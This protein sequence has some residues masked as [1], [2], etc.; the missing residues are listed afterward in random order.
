VLGISK[1]SFNGRGPD[2]TL[3]APASSPEN[4]LFQRIA[5][6]DLLFTCIFETRPPNVN[7]R[8]TSEDL[9]GIGD[10]NGV[11]IALLLLFVTR[12]EIMGSAF[13]EIGSFPCV[14]H[15]E[16][17]SFLPKDFYLISC[18]WLCTNR[19]TFL[20]RENFSRDNSGWM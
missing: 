12:G 10:R 11:T 17:A 20:G 15:P 14:F 13:G 19:S 1:D 7:V 6:G 16:N 9:V 5:I 2:I 8:S 4:S 3:S 18:H